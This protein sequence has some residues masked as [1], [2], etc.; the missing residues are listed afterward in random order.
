MRATRALVYPDRFRGNI[1]AVRERIGP[2]RRICVPVK[3]DAYGHGSLPLAR[4]ALEAGAECLAVAFVQ[5]GQE[6]RQGGVPD[7]PILLLSQ[8][9]PDE[10]GDLVRYNLSPFVSDIPFIDALAA[11]TAPITVHLKVDTGMGRAGCCPEDALAL[12]RRIVSHGGLRLG[13]IA[14]HLAV[15]D[16]LLPEDMAYTRDQLGRFRTAVEAIRDAGIDPGIVHAANSGGVLYHPDSWF[17]MVRPGILLYG[18]PPSRDATPVDVR[19]VMELHSNV[20]AIK[21]MRKGESVSYG[22][23]W[24]AP[25]DTL[26]AVVPAGYGDGLRRSL[27]NNWQVVIQGKP[28]PIV[29]RICMDQC[30]VNLGPPEPDT[31]VSTGDDVI[32]FGETAPYTAAEMAERLG[33]IPYEITC[34]IVKRVPRVYV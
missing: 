9:L 27:S 14:T 15:S 20:V 3:A 8:P 33:T 16:S 2:K 1:R 19:P 24:T 7:A 18:Y 10:L 21:K 23:T 29:G 28:Y 11:T 34:G 31:P 30:M 4:A 6:L 17:D 22:R 12:A 13:G 5:E 26:I 32:I 25:E